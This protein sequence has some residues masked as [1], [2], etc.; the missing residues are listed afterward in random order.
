M[1]DRLKRLLKN[2]YEFIEYVPENEQQKLLQ[3]L[4][5]WK[6]PERRNTARRPCAIPVDIMAGD[7]VL[8]GVIRNISSR[9]VCVTCLEALEVGQAV[10]LTFSFPGLTR[11]LKTSGRVAWCRG[12]RF[13]VGIE[14]PTRYLEEYIRER[15]KAL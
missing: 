13:G 6:H 15:I 5:Q 1:T 10:T 11:P 14:M 3:L 4:E 7:Q 2:L 8:R 12:N 9:G